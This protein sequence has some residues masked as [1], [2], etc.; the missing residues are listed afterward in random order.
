MTV[1]LHLEFYIH[2]TDILH[3]LVSDLLQN[4][5]QCC[6]ALHPAGSLG[7]FRPK[8]YSCKSECKHVSLH[9]SGLEDDL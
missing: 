1:S 4:F 9:N 2:S 8:L 5:L 6:K 7:S 3:L